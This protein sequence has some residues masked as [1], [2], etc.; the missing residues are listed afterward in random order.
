MSLPPPNIRHDEDRLG[1][2]AM[3]FRGTRR[4]AER[5]AIALEYAETVSR[6]IQSGVWN[7]MPGL[8]DQLPDNWMTSAF[9]KYWS[10]R[11]SVA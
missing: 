2:L 11:P 5:Q 7:E 6:L 1:E 10:S 3:K 4:P 9:F 8:E